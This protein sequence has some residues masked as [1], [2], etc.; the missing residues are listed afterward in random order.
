M[1][2]GSIFL[3]GYYT[4]FDYDHHRVGLASSKGGLITDHLWIHNRNGI[5]VIAVIAFVLL[6]LLSIVVGCV[7]YHF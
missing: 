5:I 2:L 1:V 6:I 3:T 7:V 4:Q